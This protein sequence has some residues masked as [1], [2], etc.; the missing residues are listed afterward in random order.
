MLPEGCSEGNGPSEA[1]S[2]LLPRLEAEGISF[3]VTVHVARAG[4]VLY[5]HVRSRRHVVT[6]VIDSPSLRDKQAAKSCYWRGI[7]RKITQTKRIAKQSIL[8]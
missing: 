1:L 4:E 6:A 2:A 8:L 5:D 7:F 3:K